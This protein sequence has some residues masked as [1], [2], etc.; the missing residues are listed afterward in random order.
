MTDLTPGET[1]AS[2]PTLLS[3]GRHA[4]DDPPPLA[5]SSTLDTV[6]SE[7]RYYRRDGWTPAARAA[8]LETLARSGVVTDACREV[9][10]SSQAAYGLRNRDRL[11]AAGWDAAVSMARP[12]LADE[13]YHRA[14]NGTV[15]QIWKDGEIVGERHRH[16]NR[17]S[18]AV[19]NRLDARTDRAEQYRA[20]S[21]RLAR[22]WATYLSAMAEDRTADVE[23]ML[24]PPPAEVDD[25][26]ATLGH[27]SNA[28]LIHQ[29]HQ[30]RQGKALD[31]N[32]EIVSGEEGDEDDQRVWTQDHSWR[33]NFPPP[34]SFFGDEDGDYGDEDYNRQCTPEEC[35]IL[36]R[37]FP[38]ASVD[39]QEESRLADEAE[40]AAY[41]AALAEPEQPPADEILPGEAGEGDRP[42]EPCS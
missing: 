2:P 30:L 26:G 22:D 23:A 34:Y 37:R 1:P 8:F 6:E 19:L 32:D 41:F 42:R 21:L 25:R 36:D 35:A 40:C 28:M 24:A 38:D 39:E 4:P 29:L 17:L 11:F 15:D 33:T 10:L 14:V 9:N 5:P 12:R 31:E 3:Y 16:D 7:T 20:P 18:I 27:G 13:L